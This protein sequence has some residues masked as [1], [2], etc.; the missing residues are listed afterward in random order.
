M[1]VAAAHLQLGP[2]SLF[3]HY[4][5]VRL[6]EFNL[7]FEYKDFFIKFGENDVLNE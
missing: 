5:Q 2:H 6:K 1:T 4:I 7:R 3:F